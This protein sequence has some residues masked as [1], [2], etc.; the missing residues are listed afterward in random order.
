MRIVK[1]VW[2]GRDN[3]FVLRLESKSPDG[4]STPIDTAAVASVLL[5]L[6]NSESLEVTSGDTEDYINWWDEELDPGEMRFVLGGWAATVPAGRYRVRLTVFT[7]ATP[8][9]VVWASFTGGELSVMII[10]ES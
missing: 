2:Q 4:V 3:E 8:N 1:Q 5:E 9:G 10:G 7:A 6:E